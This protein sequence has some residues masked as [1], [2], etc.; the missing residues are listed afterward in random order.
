[1]SPLP[2]PLG[3]LTIP[4]VALVDDMWYYGG[5]LTSPYFGMLRIIVSSF[6]QLYGT[7]NPRRVR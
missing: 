2:G 5:R 3:E 6:L 1:M 7:I 4:T